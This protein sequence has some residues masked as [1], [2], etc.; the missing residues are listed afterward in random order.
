MSASQNVRDVGKE[1]TRLQNLRLETT[2]G[3][4]GL[5]LSLPR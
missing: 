5:P 4:R 3:D 2:L 1:G